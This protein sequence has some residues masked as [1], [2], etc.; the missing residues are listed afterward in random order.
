[1]HVKSCKHYFE[2]PVMRNFFRPISL[3]GSMYKILAKFLAN[4][5]RGVLW[6]IFYQNH[7]ML[8]DRSWIQF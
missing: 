8:I 5:L 1:M 7:T 6:G 4:R 3:I 2:E